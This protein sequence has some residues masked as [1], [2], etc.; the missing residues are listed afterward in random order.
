MKI[1]IAFII[2]IIGVT[3]SCRKEIDINVPGRDRKIV[4]NTIIHTDSVFTASVFRS[5]H[6]QDR[7]FEL[8]YLNNAIVGVY[9]N[10]TLLE[11][12]TLDTLGYYRGE[13]V[14]V[15][16]GH[17]YEIKV[18]VPNLPS[19]KASGKTLAVVP[20]IAIDSIG[21]VTNNSGDIFSSYEDSYQVYEVKFNDNPDEDN[22]YRI[23]ASYLELG[24]SESWVWDSFK[25][26]SV[27]ITNNPSY[28]SVQSNDPAIE[29]WFN[30]IDGYFYFSDLYFNG[31]EY[32]LSLAIQSYNSEG[33]QNIDIYLEHISEDFF[34][35][36]KSVDFQQDSK[37]GGLFSQSVQVLSNIENGY[38]ILGTSSVSKS[39]VMIYG[40]PYDENADKIF[41]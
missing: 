2:L 36:I 24:V 7:T 12:L 34:K 28:I 5:N 9:E 11:S 41:K 30:Y 13:L 21:M 27:L 20:I 3:L 17:E 14:K 37:E 39:S 18:S 25:E 19:V 4:L 31:D 22:Y 1:Y 16:V 23:K 33:A 8:L 26:D 35:Y 15:E 32:S 6:A 40:I 10:G 29:V 38:G